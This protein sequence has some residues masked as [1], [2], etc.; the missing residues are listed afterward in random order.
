MKQMMQKEKG[1]TLLELLVVVAI[2]G[3]LS[4]G[5]LLAYEGLTEKAQAATASNNTATADQSIRN[6]RAVTQEY[7]D[8]WDSLVT[9]G[10][11]ALAFSADETNA[12]FM[13]LPLAVSAAADDFRDIFDEAFDEVGVEEIQERVAAAATQG[14]E[15]N[16]QHN[17]GAAGAD[18]AEVDFDTIT[19]FAILPTFGGAACSVNG[20]AIGLTKLDGATA[21]DATDGARQNAINDAL[22]EDECNL[23]VALG[24]GHDAAHSTNGSNVAIATAPT[25]ISENINP[26]ESYARYVALFHVGRDTGD[27]AGGAPDDDITVDELFDKARLLAVLDT[28][29]NMIDENIAN[30]TDESEN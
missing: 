13:N 3:I 7:P 20:A 27:G 15:P 6:Y 22:E 25:F 23:V 5:A 24:F 18:V 12:R 10:G 4:A 8:Q 1:F 21:V 26:N 9:S 19:N 2:I 11:A 16:L 14:V 30:A 17:E 28:E 29:G